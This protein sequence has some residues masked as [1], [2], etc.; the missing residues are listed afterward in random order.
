MTYKAREGSGAH[1]IPTNPPAL[2]VRVLCDRGEGWRRLFRARVSE[3]VNQE[4]RRASQIAGP[5]KSEHHTGT[6]GG[7]A[8]RRTMSDTRKVTALRARKDHVLHVMGKITL[9]YRCLF[10]YSAYGWQTA[11]KKQGVSVR[12]HEHSETRAAFG[13]QSSTRGIGKVYGGF[14]QNARI[15]KNFLTL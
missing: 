5:R 13:G 3:H 8:G 11:T 2:A 14:F 9:D 15:I 10:S 12:E 1:W 4:R 6:R 7:R